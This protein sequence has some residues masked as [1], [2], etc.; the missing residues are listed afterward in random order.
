MKV[1]RSGRLGRCPRREM[2]AQLYS[3]RS[4]RMLMKQLDHNLLF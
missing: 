3:V 4:K 1:P 2:H